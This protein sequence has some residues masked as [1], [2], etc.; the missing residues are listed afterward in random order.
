MG[1]ELYSL[2][3]HIKPYSDFINEMWIFF[4]T[5]DLQHNRITNLPMGVSCRITYKCLVIVSLKM[6]VEYVAAF[7]WR[8]S[9]NHITHCIQVFIT[10]IN[11]VWFQKGFENTSKNG[12][13]CLLGLQFSVSQLNF[14]WLPGT[15]CS[16]LQDE[17]QNPFIKHITSANGAEITRGFAYIRGKFIRNIFIIKKDRGRMSW[18]KKEQNTKNLCF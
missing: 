1:A 6:T 2:F 15:V 16:R 18:S 9:L 4:N 11:Y 12:I 5:A 3:S 8:L 10:L 17:E 13:M 14:H 7:K